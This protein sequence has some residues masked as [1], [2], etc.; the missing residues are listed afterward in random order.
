MIS[1]KH[2]MTPR[3]ATKQKLNRGDAETRRRGLA[4]GARLRAS[5]SPRC[6]SLS[7]LALLASWRGRI[8]DLASADP[9]LANEPRSLIPLPIP[10]T[11]SPH[12]G[13]RP[14]NLP[15]R[16]RWRNRAAE[17]FG[18]RQS[19]GGAAGGDRILGAAGR[20]VF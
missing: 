3:T 1:A 20:W 12:N 8:R 16:R 6:I 15:H 10:N 18:E 2:A 9:V 5:A 11:V 14:V 4:V 13:E 19:R 17:L 7:A